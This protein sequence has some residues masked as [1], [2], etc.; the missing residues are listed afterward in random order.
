M[1]VS[2]RLRAEI[3]RR[4]NSTCHYCGA[5]A[6][7]VKITIDHVIPV[8]LGGSDDP[9][10]LT[11]ACED[12]N[13]GKTSVPPDAATVKQISEDA[14][15]WANAIKAAGENMLG[16]RE[17]ARAA[18]DQK[19]RAW[20]EGRPPVP[21]PEDWGLSIDRFLKVG[22]P[23]SILLDCVD[24]AMSTRKVK[25]HDVFTYMCGV[26][27]KE[28]R[29]L[30]KAAQAILTPGTVQNEA[31]E[32]EC[33]HEELLPDLLD[34]L[35][36]DDRKLHGID[37]AAVLC[38]DLNEDDQYPIVAA[39]EATLADLRTDLW[40]LAGLV[41]TLLDE[42]PDGV[43]EYAMKIARHQMHDQLDTSDITRHRFSEWAI[44][45]AVHLMRVREASAYLDGLSAPERSAWMEYAETVQGASK[46]EILWSD[47]T[48]DERL[49]YA[50]HR[51]RMADLGLTH[52]SMCIGGGEIIANCPRPAAFRVLVEQRDC[53]AVDISE[54]HGHYMCESHLELLLKGEYRNAKGELRTARDFKE[55]ESKE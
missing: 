18:F 38:L 24:I 6:P 10:N 30:Q 17:T 19:W 11:T 16:E 43:G 42:L 13:A 41:D 49:T 14:F 55:L 26:A 23:L 27:W 40:S 50:A 25:A 1:A 21:R 34:L 52:R 12:C 2:K 3:F 8:T 54:G 39:V 28:V 53:C 44:H 9:S 47:L 48:S 32:Q 45:S 22:L 46:A 20:S 29:K 5:K 37:P 31:P 7:D 15:R 36:A 35:T 4:D 51:A 33:A